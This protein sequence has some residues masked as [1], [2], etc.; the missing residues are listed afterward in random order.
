MYFL[1]K[2]YKIEL[3]LCIYAKVR[4]NKSRK[5]NKEIRLAPMTQV[6]IEYQKHNMADIRTRAVFPP[7]IRE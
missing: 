5:R 1:A 2:K 4:I 7:Y 6:T 3:Q